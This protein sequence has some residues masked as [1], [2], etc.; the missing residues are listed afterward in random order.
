MKCCYHFYRRMSF[1]FEKSAMA[2]NRPDGDGE[3]R[4]HSVAEGATEDIEPIELDYLAQQEEVRL[5]PLKEDLA[6]WLNKVLGVEISAETFMNVLDNGVNVCQL[7]E[8]V[9]NKAL[10]WKASNK[11]SEILPK[12]KK[13]RY[14]SNAKSESWFARDNTANFVR[15]CREYGIK[16]ECLFESDGLVMHR[17]TRTV[18]LCLLELARLAAKFG[19]EPPNLIKLETE[20]EREEKAIQENRPIS[21]KPPSSAVKRAR[22]ANL[23]V[24]VKRLANTC[25]C[26]TRF[27]V[28]RL[29]EGR[30]NI[31]GKI[32]FIRMLKGKHLM[33]RVGGGWDTFDHY[34]QRHDPCKIK[35]FQTG[36]D[37]K[38]LYIN[39]KYKV[40]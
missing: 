20:I 21:A 14:K 36:P 15:W 23:D 35:E 33:V 32:V 6:E 17:Q 8:L 18:V 28:H 11:T 1:A 27:P 3:N 26:K 38:F 12:V 22:P 31:G 39:S 40:S 4:R 29:S 13:P 16:E 34:L 10:E 25:R 24:E 9:H 19:I 7:A 37:Q 30:Y 5:L 2:N